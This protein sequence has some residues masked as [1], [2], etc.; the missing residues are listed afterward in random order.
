MITG[1][2]PARFD[3]FRNFREAAR[4]ALVS[5]EVHRANRDPFT[6][7]GVHQ[8]TLRGMR[9]YDIVIDPAIIERRP[10]DIARDEVEDFFMTIQLEGESRIRQRSKELIM[11]PGCMAVM[12]GGGPYLVA[13]PKPSR[14][15]VLR[16][17][18]LDFRERVLGNEELLPV[19]YVAASGL[20]CIVSSLFHSVASEADNL[21]DEDQF[22]VA[23]KFLDLLAAAFRQGADG[24]IGLGR[25]SKK[26]LAG[27]VL[28][29]V[30]RHYAEAGLSP[31]RVAEANG[32]STRYLH[33][34]F[35]DSGTTVGKSIWERRL[36]ACHAELA[37]S[38]RAHLPISEIAFRQGFNDAAHFSRTFKKRYGVSPSRLRSAGGKGRPAG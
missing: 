8:T 15:L 9:I 14:R 32:I 34:L 37:D 3:R 36:E 30:A 26:D 28:D 4:N 12:A 13:Y 10:V 35:K 17:P 11:R 24:E 18:S 16:I 6:R 29:Y 20:G 7:F 19:Q 21:S 25:I 1:P 27:R 22:T 2:G 38:S 5:V 23:E 33:A 31:T